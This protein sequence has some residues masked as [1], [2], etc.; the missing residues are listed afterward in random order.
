MGAKV[1][2]WSRVGTSDSRTPCAVL[3]QAFWVS[4]LVLAQIEAGGI[5]G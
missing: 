2:N 1:K 5:Q 3:G 4:E